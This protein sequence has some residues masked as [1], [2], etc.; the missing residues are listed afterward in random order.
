MMRVRSFS[1]GLSLVLPFV[2]GLS[3]ACANEAM[4]AISIT[5][6]RVMARRGRDILVNPL[7]RNKLFSR[8]DIVARLKMCVSR[9][10]LTLYS[11]C[12][13]RKPDAREDAPK[14]G[15]GDRRGRRGARRRGG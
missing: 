12:Q 10:R 9:S 8:R 13:A 3:A 4:A 7:S 14:A 5:T 6:Q 15:R 1:F 11:K 2:F